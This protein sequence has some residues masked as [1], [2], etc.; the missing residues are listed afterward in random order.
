MR[1]MAAGT[2]VTGLGLMTAVALFLCRSSA[3]SLEGKV[4]VFLFGI[5]LFVLGGSGYA[6]ATQ[7]VS[8]E[9][10]STRREVP[11]PARRRAVGG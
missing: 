10:R 1:R 4:L 9:A 11:F 2:G 6:A 3:M 8:D 7:R 5:T